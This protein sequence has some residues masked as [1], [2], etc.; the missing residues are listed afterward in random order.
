[1]KRAVRV[2]S[3]GSAL[4]IAGFAA[5][6]A[7]SAVVGSAVADSRG[8]FP[9]NA[10]GQTYGSVANATSGNTPDLVLVEL[11]DGSTGYVNASDLAAADGGDVSTP[12]EAVARQEAQQS[13]ALGAASATS[14]SDLP[15]Y[16]SDGTTVIGSFNPFGG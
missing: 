8:G 7:G 9:V 5:G 15:V 10:H 4:A 2:L 3:I 6:V 11:P 13:Q 12:A 16:K 1:M 14:T